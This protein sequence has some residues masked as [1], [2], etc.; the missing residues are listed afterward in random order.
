METVLWNVGNI[1]QEVR[2]INSTEL[3]TFLWV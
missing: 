1:T 2:N 3:V